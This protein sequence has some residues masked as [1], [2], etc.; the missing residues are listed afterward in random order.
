MLQKFPTFKS[1]F[2]F[3]KSMP[4]GS[5][6]TWWIATAL[7]YPAKTFPAQFVVWIITLKN[8]LMWWQYL[9]VILFM[10]GTLIVCINSTEDLGGLRQRQVLIAGKFKL[11]DI[12]LLWGGRELRCVLSLG[13]TG[14]LF[15]LLLQNKKT[16]QLQTFMMKFVALQ[17]KDDASNLGSEKAL[18]IVA[19]R[20]SLHGVWRF[21]VICHGLCLRM[22]WSGNSDVNPF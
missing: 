16:S 17:T 3:E 8:L 19:F 20:Y 7:R 10:C 4:Y 1:M 14:T 13:G 5:S 22:R 18:R 6:V 15:T 2:T 21:D 9:W 12:V 11:Q